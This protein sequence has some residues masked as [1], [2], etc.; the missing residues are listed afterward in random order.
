M[1]HSEWQLIAQEFKFGFSEISIIPF[2]KGYCLSGK[3]LELLDCTILYSNRGFTLLMDGSAHNNDIFES[4]DSL[5]NAV[6]PR[7]RDA[8]H[9]TLFT[10]LSDL[11]ID[12]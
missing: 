5:L 8:F 2:D 12:Y 7:Y 11:P 3:L 9:A 10:K 6:S 4:M 1:N